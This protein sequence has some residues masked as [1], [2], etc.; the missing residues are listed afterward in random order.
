MAMSEDADLRLKIDTSSV[1]AANRGLDDF[2]Q[3]GKA[4]GGAARDFGDTTD[5]LAKSMQEM[6]L[7]QKQTND[8]LQQNIG[9]QREGTQAVD[10]HI[11]HLTRLTTGI[12]AASLAYQVFG[13]ASTDG[14]Q[15][16]NAGI[17]QQI[18]SYT[19]LTST[20]DQLA[21][22]L[23]TLSQSTNSGT[24]QRIYNAVALPSSSGGGAGELGFALMYGALAPAVTQ[25]ITPQMQAI[26]QAIQ[27]QGLRNAIDPVTL[28]RGMNT[29]AQAGVG[30]AA[31]GD[32]VA[33]MEHALQDFG[34]QAEFQRQTLKD[35]G[36][37]TKDANDALRQFI[38]VLA[39]TR[40]GVQKTQA[41]LSFGIDPG[42]LTLTTEARL[43]PVPGGQAAR[44]QSQQEDIAKVRAQ[45]AR[46]ADKVQHDEL[47]QSRAFFGLLPSTNAFT[48]G[49]QYSGEQYDTRRDILRLQ[50][51]G[52]DTKIGQG[53]E[54]A[55]GLLSLIG[56]E[57]ILNLKSLQ[58]DIG[59]YSFGLIAPP[60]TDAYGAPGP[61]GAPHVSPMT[62][63][64][65]ATYEM[66]LGRYTP[67]GIEAQIATRR[68]EG[69]DI[70]AQY[71]NVDPAAADRLRKDF[72][73][74]LKVFGER[75]RRAAD[76]VG[77]FTENLERSNA[78]LGGTAAQGA[79]D[80]A[81]LEASNA[82][83]AL[84]GQNAQLSPSQRQGV[85][86]GI[87]EGFV[88]QGVGAMRQTQ[89]QI[90]DNK[91]LA[92]AYAEGGRN[93]ATL[94]AAFQAQQEVE[95]GVGTAAGEANRTFQLLTA[96]LQD[97][98]TK[99]QENI[100]HLKEQ[101]GFS[102][103]IA[104]AGGDPVSQRA[105]QQL[106]Q[107]MGQVNYNQRYNAMSTG[108]DFVGI[109][110]MNK[111]L[112]EAVK[113]IRD[114]ETA[115]AQAAR[116]RTT[117]EAHQQQQ[118][119]GGG[120]AAVPVGAGSGG[121]TGG[122]GTGGLLSLPIT[123]G[124]HPN[125]SYNNEPYL[126]DILAHGAQSL[127]PG[128]SVQA[129]EG[130]NPSGHVANS[131]H[132]V[133]DAIDV[134]IVGP[135]GEIPNEG[136]DTTGMY[137]R[138][139]AGAQSYQRQAY[140]QADKYFRWG[141]TFGTRGGAIGSPGNV[142]DLMHYDIRGFPGSLGGPAEGG[143]GWTPPS[144][145]AGGNP[146]YAQQQA[147]LR[148]TQELQA[149][150][151]YTQTQ[152]Q[153]RAQE[154]LNEQITGLAKT[155][156]QA[157]ATEKASIELEKQRAAAIMQG[158]DAQKQLD[159]DIKI[160]AELTKLVN[161]GMDTNSAEYKKLNAQ[162]SENATH[163]LSAAESAQQAQVMRNFIEQQAASGRAIGAFTTGGQAGMELQQQ[164]EG[165]RAALVNAGVDPAAAQ[166]MAT[167][168]ALMAEKAKDTQTALTDASNEISG[169][170]KSAVGDIVDGLTKGIGQAHGFR[171]AMEDAGLAISKIGLNMFV[172]QPLQ[173]LL[174]NV[175]AGRGFNF[176]VG[177]SG[178]STSSALGTAFMS[179]IGKSLGFGGA[180]T[181]TTSS[182][183]Q[184]NVVPPNLGSTGSLGDN[185]TIGAIGKDSGN[186]N[187]NWGADIF[188]GSNSAL[189][190][191]L[192]DLFGT[193]GGNNATNG[194]GNDTGSNFGGSVS[195][196]NDTG[197]DFGGGG[198]TQTQHTGGRIYHMGSDDGI[199]SLLPDEVPA[200][201]QTGERVLSRIQ[202]AAFDKIFPGGVGN[203][204]SAASNY[205]SRNVA[206]VSNGY[207]DQMN[208][209]H[210]G[211]QGTAPLGNI[212]ALGALGLPAAGAGFGA[213]ARGA[214]SGL[215]AISSFNTAASNAA[216]GTGRLLDA[217]GMN[218]AP[219][220]ADTVSLAGQK[221][222][223]T[224][225]N[226][227]SGAIDKMGTEDIG[228]LYNAA[229]R[230]ASGGSPYSTPTYSTNQAGLR[231]DPYAGAFVDG[232]GNQWYHSGGMVRLGF[233]QFDDGGSI[234]GDLN[235]LLSQDDK[236]DATDWGSSVNL[237]NG[238]TQ[239][240][241]S[242]GVG[243]SSQSPGNAMFASLA[244]KAIGAAGDAYKTFFG[245]DN[246]L[247]SKG[248]NS[249][250]GGS[251]GA[252]D[253]T[254]GG[255]DWS[256]GGDLGGATSGGFN[257]AYSGGD[258]DLIAHAGGRIGYD[259]FPRF[260]SGVAYAPPP[261]RYNPPSSPPPAIATG[262]GPANPV[263]VN[264]N[265]YTPDANSFRASADMVAASAQTAQT[266]ALRNQ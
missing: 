210:E 171:Y 179:G 230:K 137:G 177:N 41:A 143:S 26:Y 176:N 254:G 195:G 64:A 20:L 252:S 257:N 16:A 4:A 33:K 219:T 56:Q 67:Q 193:R 115:D 217:L 218:R 224:I 48:S 53:G 35:Y 221:A 186:Q 89:D 60:N 202:S 123:P 46:L 99:A 57:A 188:G 9:V 1:G 102:A 96:S 183:T 10:D 181:P 30:P 52:T 80:R 19:Q 211:R 44:E 125:L 178:V 222:M 133:G 250:F 192:I 199:D 23:Q 260:H 258:G 21:A 166:Q 138:L 213:M 165:N 247:I 34:E 241:P 129:N 105:A 251:G 86:G 163:Q 70:V 5:R 8:L 77:V 50:L 139:F 25:V 261:P 243:K 127:P 185:G 228:A 81:L 197:T 206:A 107:A 246:G 11:Q 173:T 43:H 262:A 58:A 136:T 159:A 98:D 110:A 227:M 265:I 157:N 120:G 232:K 27:Q 82:N 68:R 152:V 235:T 209:F 194:N 114:K 175:G 72:E 215:E 255:G 234:S 214:S 3:K 118:I 142:A 22:K 238:G 130:Y 15:A 100:M 198:N 229:L 109:A 253:A 135:N 54:G 108:G 76:P 7:L 182:G 132:H 126:A 2:A 83:R 172:T 160:Q 124:R 231:Y 37:T 113:A 62:A 73:D 266:R 164:S 32:M 226:T 75:L 147:T 93:V 170:M 74:A 55:G 6:I 162:L 140:P 220:L 205:V 131:A 38:T 13:R 59:R 237:G 174:G 90:D 144:A 78:V 18:S 106:N 92:E 239:S 158:G 225:G 204:M 17:Q 45:A 128:Y 242:A 153:Q 169:A 201:L 189:G 203:M 156:E 14:A 208:A 145:P 61:Q 49:G 134:R 249:L 101:A 111:E 116:Q 187:S 40:D 63:E 65:A 91:K 167:Q 149:Q 84:Y 87:T 161:S 71:Q 233:P 184:G 24:Y 88:G 146:L 31:G 259:S 39:N 190:R 12:N 154:I 155:T 69:E 216:G 94:T 97:M 223:G 245:G 119:L 103:N 79:I 150:G 36:V 248:W 121:T 112:D 263:V 196:G 28:L 256:G 29:G 264:Q 207:L 191:G 180:S 42:M 212:S 85:I 117:F 95:K 122:T 151:P 104:G 148:A 240:G 168:M 51:R 200:I 47:Q 141:G 66:S 236:N 244:T